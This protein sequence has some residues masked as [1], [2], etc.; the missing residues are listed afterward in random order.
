MDKQGKQPQAPD[1]GTGT[2]KARSFPCALDIAPS[3]RLLPASRTDEGGLP[4]APWPPG[5]HQLSPALCGLGLSNGA[6]S[7]WRRPLWN[8]SNHQVVL[9]FPSNSLPIPNGFPL[10]VYAHRDVAAGFSGG[11]RR[12]YAVAQSSCRLSPLGCIRNSRLNY[13]TCRKT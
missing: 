10:T 5:Y 2:F 7:L 11:P 9:C 8:P 13:L 6:P 1:F 3:P 4:R 12:N